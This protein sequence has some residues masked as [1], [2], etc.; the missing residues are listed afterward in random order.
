[1]TEHIHLSWE[2]RFEIV[3]GSAFYQLDGKMQQ[4]TAGETILMPAKLKHIHP[5][6]AGEEEMVYRQVAKFDL[7]NSEA[8]DEI[9][10]TFFTLFDLEAQ[11][12][13]NKKGLPKNPLQF[14]ATLRSLTR[15]EGYDAAVPITLQNVLAASLGR[16]SHKMGYRAVSHEV[17]KKANGRA[18]EE[19]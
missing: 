9:I 2:E 7:P 15:H 6:N 3:A 19:L 17:V 4:A 12:K 1:M 11:G 14:A 13:L 5:W 10:G 16:L 8:T 18:V